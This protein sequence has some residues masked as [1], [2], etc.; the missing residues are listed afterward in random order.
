MEDINKKIQNMEL[1]IAM[2]RMQDDNTPQNRS[3]MIS[4]MMRT[5]FITPAVV[6]PEEEEKV[7]RNKEKGLKTPIQ[8]SFKVVTTKDGRKFLPAFTDTIQMKEWKQRCNITDPVKN[9]VMNFDVYAQYVF[10]SG[11]NLAGFIINPFGENIVFPEE[12]MRSLLKQ[13]MQ[14]MARAAARKAPPSRGGQGPDGLLS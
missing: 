6:S 4:E 5:R 11:G 3:R 7:R 1:I 13:K 8:V 14:N 12:L 9:M 2:R 10:G